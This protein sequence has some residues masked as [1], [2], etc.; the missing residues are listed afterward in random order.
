MWDTKAYNLRPDCSSLPCV[1]LPSI[2][3]HKAPSWMR[4]FVSPRAPSRLT[5]HFYR[6]WG[7]GGGK[8]DGYKICCDRIGK[9]NRPF[10][11]H[12]SRNFRILSFFCKIY[13]IFITKNIIRRFTSKFP[14]KFFH[15]F[16]ETTKYLHFRNLSFRILYVD[17]SPPSVTPLR[18]SVGGG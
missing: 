5:P 4:G 18:F 14:R 7:G 16:N 1:W 2:V 13:A 11:T 12:I 9:K 17:K 10:F 15:S 6:G 3:R 8:V